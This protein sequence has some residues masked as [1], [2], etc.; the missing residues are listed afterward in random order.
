MLRPLLHFVWIGSLLFALD[1]LV[2]AMPAAP[3]PVVIPPG[4]VED[5]RAAFRAQA[6]RAPSDPELA[7]LVR[8]EVDDELLYRE[9][10]A[11]G[12][13]HDD[14]VVQRRLVQNMRFAGA[15]PERTNEALY[16]EALELGM[17]RSDPVVRRRLVQRMRLAIESRALAEEPGEEA[18]RAH[19][20]E[21]RERWR[22]PA[23]V[24]LVQL[25][26]DGEPEGEARRA[27]EALRGE[28]PD[29]PEDLG[30]PFLHA[31][32]QPP[33]SERELAARFGAGFAGEAFA[34]AEGAWSGPIASSY[35]EHLV[36]VR[37]RVPA[38]QRPF[39]A[40]R[41]EVRLAVLAER[42]REAFAEALASLRE[43]V[44]V[45]VTP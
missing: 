45:V 8:A 28:G 26:F 32:R 23:R 40:V 1:R 19:Y 39:D 44:P 36:Y 35:G 11:S 16:A 30:E 20:D 27:L 18:L 2:L 13:L 22:E 4:R 33:Q 12:F 42:R 14:P 29:P 38:S 43:G 7:G 41:S 6:G 5:L 24:S 15:D 17:E 3:D 25:Y 31:A 9:A 34:L 10:L 21:N 37:E